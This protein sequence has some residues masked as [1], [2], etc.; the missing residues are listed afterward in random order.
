ML[1]QDE[2]PSKQLVKTIIEEQTSH[3]FV[4]KEAKVLQTLNQPK[5]GPLMIRGFPASR[6]E[7][8]LQA[9]LNVKNE[10]QSPESRQ[11]YLR[12]KFLENQE[13]TRI[14]LL[15]QVDLKNRKR[16]PRNKVIF[17]EPVVTKQFE[18]E[19]TLWQDTECDAVKSEVS[20]KAGWIKLEEELEASLQPEITS[21]TGSSELEPRSDEPTNASSETLNKDARKKR[22]YEMI[23]N[24]DD[25][26]SQS[27]AESNDDEGG[28]FSSPKVAKIAP[29][30]HDHKDERSQGLENG[31]SRFPTQSQRSQRANKIPK[32]Y[33]ADGPVN[34]T[35]Q[36]SKQVVDKP[37]QP[38]D[39]S[40][41]L[42][43]M[44][45]DSDEDSSEEPEEYFDATQSQENNY[46]SWISNGLSFLSS[47]MNKLIS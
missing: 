29:Y 20:E 31:P 33:L 34:S 19:P 10:Q 41:E 24:H 12:Q 22:P 18:Y 39:A 42:L 4:L 7:R 45:K 27:S 40:P 9:A 3:G 1:N 13:R 5:P 16:S 32:L 6:A 36:S 2:E 37:K 30:Y 28:L 11:N 8:I 46:F 26:E 15:Q 38:Q 43:N 17:T 14:S 47:T 44:K 21:S 25:S 35:V 23:A